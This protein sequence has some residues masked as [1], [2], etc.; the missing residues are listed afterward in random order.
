MGQ[1]CTTPVDNDSSSVK[2]IADSLSHGDTADEYEELQKMSFMKKSQRNIQQ[3]TPTGGGLEN[4]NVRKTTSTPSLGGYSPPQQSPPR[5]SLRTVTGESG[6]T[7]APKNEL[8][9]A[10]APGAFGVISRIATTMTVNEELKVDHDARI[11]NQLKDHEGDRRKDPNKHFVRNRWGA[12]KNNLSDVV[13]AEKRRTLRGGQFVTVDEQGD[14]IS[15]D[16]KRLGGISEGNEDSQTSTAQQAALPAYSQNK[17]GSFSESRFA[18]NAKAARSG[19]NPAKM[20]RLRSQMMRG[21][22]VKRLNSRKNGLGGGGGTGSTKTIK[23]I[24]GGEAIGEIG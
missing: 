14:V 16:E 18:H 6:D 3:V 21:G 2:R 1:Q 5:L 8:R 4:V 22:S 11:I 15:D 24:N 19:V 10:N 9:K 13:L 23:G 17:R 12:L 20:R 7:N